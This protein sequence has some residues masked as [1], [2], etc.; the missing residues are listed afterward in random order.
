MSSL[1][2]PDVAGKHILNNR[3]GRPFTFD[4]ETRRALA[5]LIRQH[6]ATGALERAPVS[7]SMATLLKIAREFKIPLKPGRRTKRVA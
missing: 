7:I 2:E 6:G 3:R 5:A 1:D 4:Q